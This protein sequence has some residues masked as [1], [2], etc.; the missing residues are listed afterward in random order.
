MPG[1]KIIC[2]GSPFGDDQFGAWAY[3]Q[4]RTSIAPNTAQLLYLDRPGTRLIGALDGVDNLILIDAVKS[5]A[6]IGSVLR[7]EGEGIYRNLTRHTSTH[8][9][10]VADALKL[11]QRLGCLPPSLILLGVEAGVTDVATPMS[12]S[13]RA[14]FPNLLRA[15]QDLD[16]GFDVGA[17]VSE[18]T[19]P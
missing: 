15:L 7:I 11:A 6:A 14:A 9:F 5:G 13:M 19:I 4:L 17:T 10:G 18:S 1:T 3:E 16:I 12:E 8:G 2:I